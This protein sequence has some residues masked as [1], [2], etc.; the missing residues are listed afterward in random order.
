VSKGGGGGAAAA[1]RCARSRPD[2]FVELAP[3]TDTIAPLKS[4]HATTAL[5]VS[6]DTVPPPSRLSLCARGKQRG[7][8]SLSPLPRSR[9]RAPLLH[10]PKNPMALLATR[11][12]ASAAAARSTSGPTAAPALP[13][14]RALGVVVA[15]AAASS[16]SPLPADA[17]TAAAPASR[18]AA[19]LALASA[20]AAASAAPAPARADGGEYATF[21]GY[22][23]PPTSYGG[24]GG[25]AN[26][27]RESPCRRS[28]PT[29]CPRPPPAQN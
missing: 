14:A 24:Y 9:P 20:A 11:R 18:R 28:S 29:P 16:S 4:T 8:V 3:K 13:R 19:L 21:L 23:T 27:P 22:A 7:L 10:P 17:D 5:I 1:G 26:E 25:N 2:F 15:A 6:C 12:G